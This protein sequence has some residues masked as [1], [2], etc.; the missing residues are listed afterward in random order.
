MFTVSKDHGFSGPTF[1]V[2]G[3]LLPASDSRDPTPLLACVTRRH[4]QVGI[5]PKLSR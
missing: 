1:Q 2:D 5:L 3:M 4:R